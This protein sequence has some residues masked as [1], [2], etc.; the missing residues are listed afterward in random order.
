MPFIP[1]HITMPKAASAAPATMGPMMRARLNWMELSA[2]ALGR[3]SLFTSVGTSVWYAGP[4]KACAQPVMN[5]SVRMCQ[6]W[7][8]S[9]KTRPA[10]TKAVVIWTT[11]DI[12]IMWRRS[13]RSAT[14]PAT[15]VSSRMGSSPMKLSSPR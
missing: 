15:S 7:M 1:K 5:E 3:C 8:A 10:R 6:T 13:R 14:T 2:M 11:C 12:S 9:T 4:P